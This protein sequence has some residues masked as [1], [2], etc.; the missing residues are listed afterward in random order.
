MSARITGTG[1]AVP[2]SIIDNDFLSNIVDTNDEW[3]SSRTGI[4]RRRIAKEAESENVVSL[5]AKAA[6]K[7]IANA[8]ILSESIE[9]IIVATMSPDSYM[10]NT[11]CSVQAEIGANKAVCF[12]INAACSGFVFALSCAYSFISQGMYKKALV[13]GAENLSKLIDW[14]DRGTCVLF[15]DG[16]GAVVLEADSETGM[17]FVQGSDGSRADALT[18]RGRELNNLLTGEN[19]NSLRHEDD[20][21][22]MDGQEVFKFAVKKVPECI[23]QVLEKA[24]ASASDIKY[25]CLHQANLRIIKSVA[26]RLGQPEDK[27]PVNLTE[28]GNTS[29]ASIPILLDELFES[30]KLLKGDKIVIAGFGAGLTWGSALIEI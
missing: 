14:E 9:L 12:D 4:K 10:P 16:A 21:I 27:F 17:S 18:I 28:Y 13:I 29:G 30:G 25:F 5:A 6:N 7:A 8:G 24:E 11:A 2:S 15:G 23:N 22:K 19:K 3:I 26:K 20:Y 1:S